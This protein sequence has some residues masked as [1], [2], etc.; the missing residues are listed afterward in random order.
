VSAIPTEDL[1]L[2]KKCVAIEQNDHGV[3]ARFEDGTKEEGEVLIGADGLHSITRK[4]IIGDDNVDGAKFSGTT[5][6][7]GI[8]NPIGHEL[9]LDVGELC[10]LYGRGRVYGAWHLKGGAVCFFNTERSPLQQDDIKPEHMAVW[11]QDTEKEL[12]RASNLW[13]PFDIDKVIRA[14]KRVVKLGLFQ[15]EKLETWYNNRITLLGDAAHQMLPSGGQGGNTA[16]EDAT[17]LAHL[18]SQT[19]LAGDP[20]QE[21]FEDYED[22]RQ[23]RAEKIAVMA[24]R[25]NNMQTA[26]NLLTM[27]IRDAM[28]KYVDISKMGRMMDWIL[29][30]QPTIEN[31]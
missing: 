21:A 14:K 11:S 5:M 16:I 27:T 3:V 2:G 17:V 9:G 24:Q 4:A 22:A 20:L 12:K 6:L 31:I 28:Y 25:M 18:M 15:T 8:T 26:D 19:A 13:Y 1:R 23:E 10:F 29:K 30:Y 7:F